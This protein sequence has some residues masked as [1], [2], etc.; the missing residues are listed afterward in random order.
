MPTNPTYSNGFRVND[1]MAALLNR[2][3]WRQP[4]SSLFPFQ[5]TDNNVW[6]N[7]NPYGI[8]FES[9][10]KIVTPL[11]IFY[12]QENE[13]ISQDDFNTYLQ[14]LQSDAILKVLKGVF[15]KS[16]ALEKKLLFERYGRQDYVNINTGA[17]VGVKIM[18]ARKFDITCQIDN[19][20]LKFTQDASFNL[21]LIH[22]AQPSIYIATI[23]VNAVANAQTVV[24]IG[25]MLSY[26]GNGNKSGQYFLGYFQNDLGSA[27]AINEIIER[28]N[29]TYNFGMVPIEMNV[30]NGV[31]DVNNHAYTIKTHGFN[32]QMSAFRDYTQ[33]IVDN[34]YLF[35]N[36]IG[37]QVAADVIELI[38]NS[39]RTDLIK[40]ISQE[41]SA[42]LYRDLNTAAS[43]EQ[44][45]FTTG[46]KERIKREA[47]RVKRELF[48]KHRFTSI[49]H[50]TND[51]PLYN[52]SPP[53]ADETFY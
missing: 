6:G 32:I 40:R 17:F 23:P 25:Q 20:A 28:F 7:T 11:N 43:T 2:T 3:R 39:T 44:M 16:E 41:S 10:H 37:L 26:S 5:L 49:T 35:D 29:D 31:I 47:D 34:A 53:Q 33:L 27:Q 22:D 14:N 15:N 18:P 52:Y 45:P 50:D 36:L 46:L 38:Q 24:N 51:R 42:A 30:V 8:V 4:S 21:Y 13:K 9:V 12:S 48:P 19:V 1:V